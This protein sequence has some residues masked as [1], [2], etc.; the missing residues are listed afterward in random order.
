M[1]NLRNFSYPAPH[2]KRFYASVIDGMI[3]LLLSQ[4]IA[5]FVTQDASAG[6]QIMAALALILI[7]PIYY[8]TGHGAFGT[9]PGKKAMGLELISTDTLEKPSWG[10]VL[11]RETIG[12]FLSGGTFMLGYFLIL[13]NSEHKGLHDMITKTQVV[14]YNPPE[15]GAWIRML[16]GGAAFSAI[17][18]A[19]GFYVLF[20]TA[21]PLKY[22]AGEFEKAGLH[23]DGIQGNLKQ[24][25]S[26]GKVTWNNERFQFQG[27]NLAFKYEDFFKFFSGEPV[28]L[29]EIHA[30]RIDLV[31]A[32]LGAVMPA[33][34]TKPAP[35]VSATASTQQ[36]RKLPGLKVD[37]VN[38]ENFKF[39]L[40]GKEALEFNRFFLS[41]F[42][43]KDKAIQTERLWLDS[44][45]LVLD[46]QK[47]H[48]DDSQIHFGSS[49]VL[50][51]KSF[52]PDLLSGDLDFK[53]SGTGIISEKN[54]D[55]KISGLRNSFSAS[56]VKDQL[57][58]SIQNL[59]PHWYF[60]KTPPVHSLNL[61]YSGP[62]AQFFNQPQLQGGYY[63]RNK[64]FQ[65][66]SP[67][68]PGQLFRAESTVGG[69]K[70][71]ASVEFSKP[72]KSL[73]SLFHLNLSSHHNEV[74]AALAD[75]YYSRSQNLTIPEAQAVM[76]DQKHF[77]FQKV[78][79][80]RFEDLQTVQRIRQAHQLQVDLM[81]Q[82]DPRQAE[83]ERALRELRMQ[84]MRKPSSQSR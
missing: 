60:Q 3:Q 35:T 79:E 76:H 23:M 50:I 71:Y 15:E 4:A 84:F 1:Q 11:G 49:S 10:Q 45:K 78:P 56:V 36:K 26:A 72:T 33:G 22:M 8:I 13:V 81:R 52:M 24:G 51:R 59:Q 32:D 9:T 61:K 6:T 74:T 30:S 12:R 63:I 21:L 82:R 64:P 39:G 83:K 34:S 19:V 31:M 77:T 53:F 18:W 27:E 68:I 37:Q 54:Y 25:F 7:A 75:I 70:I 62:I 14:T 43:L 55:L 47:I 57:T 48:F 65:F 16:A 41:K 46:L 2:G 38:I 73:S 5:L 58:V 28:H 40:A 42:D 67:Q 29:T 69:K 44:K 17:S 20:Y 80:V 66:S